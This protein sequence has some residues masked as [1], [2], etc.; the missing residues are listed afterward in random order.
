MSRVLAAVAWVVVAL[1]LGIACGLVAG[2]W[3]KDWSFVSKLIINLIK[4]A[5]TPLVFFAVLEAV[6][7]HHIAGRDFSKLL[8]IVSLNAVIAITIGLIVANV[9]QPGQYLTFLASE[10]TELKNITQTD[11]FSALQKQIPTNVV[12]PFADNDV[13]AVVILALLF[14]FAW[15]AVKARQPDQGNQIAAAESWISFARELTEQVLI[16]IVKLV[17]L[18]VFFASAKVANEH[19]LAP[20]ANLGIYVG[21]CLLGMVIHLLL[22]YSTWLIAVARIGLKQFWQHAAQP[23]LYAFGVN[24]S[25]VALPL[26]LRALDTLGISRRASTLTA[27]IGTN[28]NNDGII[29]YEAFTLIAIAQAFGVDM[30]ITTQLF[31]A[32]YCIVAAMG[33]AGVPEAGVVALTLVMTAFGLPLEAL[34]VLLSVDWIIARSR[35]VLNVGSD[36]VGA[37]VLQR[38]LK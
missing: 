19:G 30:S 27:C 29:L 17:P 20:F 31:A 5:A 9:F 7:R 24:S 12:Q 18:A 13:M 2:P 26:T 25:L 23:M 37:C 35:S 15:R 33:V 10:H 21:F 4:M 16:W 36:M 6:I 8:S 22:T 1:C 11:L 28:L 32:F 38:W 3:I 34:A 14:A